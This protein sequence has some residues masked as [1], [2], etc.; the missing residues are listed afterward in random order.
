[1]EVS[2][3]NPLKNTFLRKVCMSEKIKIGSVSLE[4]S[5]DYILSDIAEVEKTINNIT[6]T[7]V[8]NIIKNVQN[9]KN[10]RFAGG[11]KNRE[12]DC[13]QHK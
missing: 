9:I 3:E 12:T 5:E 11:E 2:L 6:N 13:R 8:E 7:A 10:I 4:I 1:M